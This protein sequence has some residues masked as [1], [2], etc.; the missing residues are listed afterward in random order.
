MSSAAATELSPA[1][2]EKDK[3]ISE[4]RGYNVNPLWKATGVV[5]PKPTPAASVALWKYE[6][7]RPLMLTAARLIN[8]E[9]AQRRVLI[10]TNPSM[11]PPYTTDTIT[12]GLQLIKPGETAAAHRHRAFAIR[13]IIEGQA[14]FTSVEGERIA[15]ETGD[16]VLT[17]S[18]TWHD[19]GLDG[20]DPMIWL[21]ANDLPIYH[22]LPIHFAEN[23]P[24]PIYQ[25]KPMDNDDPFRFPWL[26]MKRKLDLQCDDYV[27]DTYRR[28]DGSHVSST[29]GAHALRLKAGKTSTPARSTCSFVF[30]VQAGSGRTAIEGANGET[31]TLSWTVRDT[32]AV[33]SWSR[34]TH[35]ADEAVDAYLVSLSDMPLLENL[36]MYRTE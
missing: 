31:K 17:P 10:L 27:Q 5:A 19:H 23:F 24:D 32:F 1:V 28:P 13:F 20:K 34:I 26:N 33:P 15:M 35:I 29:L 36:N 22:K 21:D 16:L 12:C 11:K 18:W 6:D 9:E 7:L 2:G 25:T 4:L 14:G 30:H 3:Y 8:A